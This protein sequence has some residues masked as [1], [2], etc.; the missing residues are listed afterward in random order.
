MLLLGMGKVKIHASKVF[1]GV[2]LKTTIFI[3]CSDKQKE[4]NCEWQLRSAASWISKLKLLFPADN[5]YCW[6]CCFTGFRRPIAIYVNA[7]AQSIV[8]KLEVCPRSGR[9]VKVVAI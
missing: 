7:E 9:A 6:Y 2:Y 4:Q 8:C 5:V 1:E 3:Y